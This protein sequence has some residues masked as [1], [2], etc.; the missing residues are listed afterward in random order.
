M[1]KLCFA[2]AVLL[3]IPSARLFAQEWSAAQKEVWKVLESMWDLSS[4]GDV[5]GALAFADDDISLWDQNEP[6]PTGKVS[7]RKWAA[8]AAKSGER[9]LMHELRPVTIKVFPE[10][11][12][13]HYYMSSVYQQASTAAPEYGSLRITDIFRK[14]GDRWLWIGGHNSNVPK[15]W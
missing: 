1:K 2:V 10:F 13:V 8:Y 7:L 9:T 12:F 4:K 6:L 15:S 3:L 11:A 14:K 5:E